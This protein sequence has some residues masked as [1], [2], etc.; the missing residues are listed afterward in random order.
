MDLRPWSIAYLNGWDENLYGFPTQIQD[1]IL[2]KIEQMK[3]PLQGRG[4][5]HSRI[6]VEEVGEHR[7]AYSI[8]Q[9]TRTKEIHFVGDH[10]QY[11]K[12]YTRNIGFHDADFEFGKEIAQTVSL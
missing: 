1:Q 12:W 5:H 10:K 11:E 8:N 4:L 2:K 9:S 3:Q 6:L 7:I